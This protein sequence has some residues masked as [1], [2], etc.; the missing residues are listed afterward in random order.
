GDYGAAV[1][2]LWPVSRA[3]HLAL[4]WMEQAIELGGPAGARML[5]RQLALL[6][7][8]FA[9]VL[10]RALALLEDEEPEG[11]EAR[12]A[13]ARALWTGESREDAR[14]LARPAARAV[15]RDAAG[16]SIDVPPADARALLRFTGDGALRADMVTVPA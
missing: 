15:V 8:A 1:E 9:S 11:A 2:A 13:F 4:P 7:E 10:P 5:A 3:R 14:A 12:L 16:G 6:P